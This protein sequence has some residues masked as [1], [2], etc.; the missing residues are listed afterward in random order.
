MPQSRKV[1]AVDCSIGNSIYN[2]HQIASISKAYSNCSSEI[3]TIRIPESCFP[4]RDLDPKICH[5]TAKVKKVPSLLHGAAET[6]RLPWRSAAE[7]RGRAGGPRRLRRGRASAA[8]SPGGP[9]AA[10]GPRALRHA[11]VACV[12]NL[13]SVLHYLGKRSEAPLMCCAAVTVAG[14]WCCILCWEKIGKT[15]GKQS[16]HFQIISKFCHLCRSAIMHEHV[17]A[18]E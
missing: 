12:H 2:K 14:G 13:A 18:V 15:A 5:D 4:T 6:F 7:A 17:N 1:K 16:T 8:P 9:R 10:P 3:K 11:G